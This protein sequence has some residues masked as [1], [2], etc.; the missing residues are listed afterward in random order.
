M[1]K[2]KKQEDTLIKKIIIGGVLIIMVILI[3]FFYREKSATYTF[4]EI[5]QSRK[6]KIKF[7]IDDY[8]E[9]SDQILEYYNKGYFKNY[10]GS[11]GNT[12]RRNIYFKDKD[13]KELF[14]ITELGNNNLI[15]L[16]IDGKERMYQFF[17]QRN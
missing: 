1:V 9:K 15:R 4:S 16:S 6:K 10:S 5:S 8:N 11:T 3:S 17:P 7:V 14:R 13:G 2:S 12:S